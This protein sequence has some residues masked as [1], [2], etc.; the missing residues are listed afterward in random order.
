[1]QSFAALSPA[2]CSDH[3]RRDLC[4][5]ATKE[6]AM[7]PK[8]ERVVD[9]H[10]HLWDPAN[11][12]WYPYLSG[13]QDVGLGDLDRW[14]RYFDQKTYFAEAA[15]W[16]VVKFVHVAAATDFVAETMEKDAEAHATGHPDAIIGGLTIWDPVSE[17]IDQLDRQMLSNRFRG[18]RP[19][20]GGRTPRPSES[21]EK[22]RVI[23]HPDVLSALAER[24]LIFEIMTHP[25]QL[26]EGARDLAAWDG[27]LTVVIEHTGWP[28]SNSEDEFRV[29]K[30]GMA[31]LAE[32]GPHV[33]CK[34]S[35]LAMPL[36]SMEPRVFQPW[37][38]YCL[39]VFGTERCFFASNFPPDGRGGTFDD[40]YGTFDT[41][42]AELDAE[43]R[44]M[45]FAANAERVYRC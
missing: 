5:P 27:E 21:G 19:M 24:N 3:R 1:M 22:P 41:L 18:V 14:A 38:E 40:L 33:H 42:T 32:V 26:G 10:V 9:A 8:V 39:E 12:D 15:A 20:G 17:C 44:D 28:H 13:L 7:P 35:G 16:N 45:L 31:A 43:A 37:I 2:A 36:G 6:E 34:L 29:W 30:T 25:D 4:A 11:T 23:P